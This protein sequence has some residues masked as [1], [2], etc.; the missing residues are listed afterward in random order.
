MIDGTL[1]AI[2][3]AHIQ[4]LSTASVSDLDNLQL[5]N[6]G[7]TVQ[8]D[9]LD[10]DIGVAGLISGVFGSKAWMAELGRRGGK[11]QS[12]AKAIAARE[13]GQKGGRPT[14]AAVRHYWVQAKPQPDSITFAKTNL[15]KTG[16]P[17]PSLGECKT[18]VKIVWDDW[19]G[20]LVLPHADLS[21]QN[22]LISGIIGGKFVSQNINSI[23]SFYKREFFVIGGAAKE[24]AS[25]EELALAA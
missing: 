13:N 17:E 19:F 20:K 3:I 14:T 16:L 21:A 18:R 23:H 11:V 12:E 4:G 10:L 24:A 2:P 5:T 15:A 9:R 22:I 25:N 6:H 8:F 7:D 1:I